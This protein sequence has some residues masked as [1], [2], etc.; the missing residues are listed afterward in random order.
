M[1]PPRISIIVPVYNVERYL[2]QCLDSIIGQSFRDI[3]ILCIHDASPDGSLAILREY[4]AR[5]PRLIILDQSR[6]Q[7][8]SVA[9]HAGMEV[10]RGEFL[11]FVDPDD[12]VH[13]DLCSKVIARATASRADV[14]F[15][16]YVAVSDSGAV[17]SRVP[18]SR[19]L[20]RANPRD[21]RSL[22]KLQHFAWTKLIRT[23]RAREIQLR[24]PE[25]LHYADGLVHWMLVA[26]LDE[27]ALLP[28]DLYYYRQRAGSIVTRTDWKRADILVV[29][30]QIRDMLVHH[31]LYE[32]HRAT[33]LERELELYYMLHDNIAPE[34]RPAVMELFTRRKRSGEWNQALSSADWRARD[35]FRAAEGSLPARIRR[36]LWVMVRWCYRRARALR[37]VG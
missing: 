28:E 3:E 21:K 23:A 20:A 6:N 2:R 27:F 31:G 25:G 37:G 1:T 22:L 15:F 17:M 18:G 10:A 36:G 24:F 19:V 5:D 13:P 32:E 11:L 16:G 12:Y 7:G 26:L 34:H 4:A 8:P 9:R 29:N 14:V 35:F 33:F 30:D